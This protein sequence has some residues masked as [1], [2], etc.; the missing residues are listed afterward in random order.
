MYLSYLDPQTTNNIKFFLIS[1]LF[2]HAGLI[3]LLFIGSTHKSV[4]PTYLSVSLFSPQLQRSGGLGA[5]RTPKLVNT[6]FKKNTNT[7]P[8]SSLTSKDSDLQSTQ[9]DSAAN[10][11]KLGDGLGQTD[12]DLSQSTDPQAGLYLSELSQ[13]LNRFKSYPQMAK[14]L[15]IE[16][17]V[18]LVV[19]VD[20][21][22][23]EIKAIKTL[24]ADHK[25]LEQSA[26]NT[27]KRISK[28]PKIPLVISSQTFTIT[29]PLNYKFQ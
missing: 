14:Q 16:G 3:A 6:K 4:E 5:V 13:L 25:I 27:I 2:L 1:S 29:I 19:T 18:K 9:M 20:T 21:E 11:E 8:I 10:Q 26:I 28:F 15:G 23:G 17:L 12:T 22:S 7:A 24:H